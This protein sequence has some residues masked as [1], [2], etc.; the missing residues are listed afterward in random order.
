MGDHPFWNCLYHYLQ[1]H[2]QAH[3][4][5]GYAT[6]C[7]VWVVNHTDIRTFVITALYGK[8]FSTSSLL[9]CMLMKILGS[10][11][12]WCGRGVF[13]VL[14]HINASKSYL[15]ANTNSNYSNGQE[16]CIGSYLVEQKVYRLS[17]TIL[18]RAK[19]QVTIAISLVLQ[20]S[21]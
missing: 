4:C 7:V 15:V 11:H 8:R 16:L 18:Y 1:L 19:V 10:K 12:P 13:S 9:Y 6:G 3:V 21:M 5:T 2:W 14:L 20:F 17:G